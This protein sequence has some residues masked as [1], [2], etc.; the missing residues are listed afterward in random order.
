MAEP[1]PYPS[2]NAHIV[3]AGPLPEVEM[4]SEEVMQLNFYLPQEVW[5]IKL[6]SAFGQFLL[7]QLPSL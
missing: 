6:P 7:E 4:I 5:G 3:W 1:V 2:G